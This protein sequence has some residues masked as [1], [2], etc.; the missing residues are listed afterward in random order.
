IMVDI[1]LTCY[2]V[3]EIEANSEKFYVD[4]NS[5]KTVYELQKKIK[6]T[7]DGIFSNVRA[8]DLQLSMIRDD[9]NEDVENLMDKLSKFWE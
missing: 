3:R 4:I 5:D 1:K 6:E 9:A 2:L 7:K 8:Q